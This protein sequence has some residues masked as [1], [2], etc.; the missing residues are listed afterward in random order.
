MAFEWQRAQ[1]YQLLALNEEMF[2]QGHISRYEHDFIRRLQAEKLT[3]LHP[4]GTIGTRPN[5]LY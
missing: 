5:D 2:R 3:N 4:R 1:A